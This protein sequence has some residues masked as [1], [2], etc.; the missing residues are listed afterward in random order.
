M[1]TRLFATLCLFGALVGCAATVA[2]PVDA[3]SPGSAAGRWRDA[4]E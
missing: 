4:P 1:P 3:P 2:K